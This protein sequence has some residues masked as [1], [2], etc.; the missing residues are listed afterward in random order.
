M[1]AC[2]DGFDVSHDLK[3]T[4]GDRHLAVGTVYGTNGYR[5]KSAAK[6]GEHPR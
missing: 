2:D 4:A 1:S 6:P 3:R 5:A